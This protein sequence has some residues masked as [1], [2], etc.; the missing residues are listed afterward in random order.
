MAAFGEW[1][2]WPFGFVSATLV[3]IGSWMSRPPLVRANAMTMLS[4]III[5]RTASGLSTTNIAP[6]VSEGYWPTTALFVVLLPD[7]K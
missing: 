7:T 5:G 4:L 2:R 6:G 3:S 1:I